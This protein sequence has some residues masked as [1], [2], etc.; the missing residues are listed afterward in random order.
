MR[1]LLPIL[2]LLGMMLS[3]GCAQ[4]AMEAQPQPRLQRPLLESLT[5]TKDRGICLGP[6]DAAELFLYIRALE[7]RQP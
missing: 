1:K 6:E 3:V 5:T 7:E 2:L 4:K